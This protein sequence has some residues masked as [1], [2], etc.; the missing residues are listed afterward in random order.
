MSPDIILTTPFKQ[1][2]Y[3]VQIYKYYLEKLNNDRNDEYIPFHP[4]ENN[5]ILVIDSGKIQPKQ[6]PTGIFSYFGFAEEG[7]IDYKSKRFDVN[8]YNNT[9]I[10]GLK[11]AIIFLAEITK[12]IEQNI[13]LQ[14]NMKNFEQ[15]EKFIPPYEIDSF[16]HH[17]RIINDG[18]LMEERYVKFNGVNGLFE[19][20]RFE[21][22]DLYYSNFNFIPIFHRLYYSGSSILKTKPDYRKYGAIIMDENY[23]THKMNQTP[24]HHCLK[25]PHNITQIR[26]PLIQRE[27][28]Y[29]RMMVKIIIENYCF[30]LMNMNKFKCEINSDILNLFGIIENIYRLKNPMKYLVITK[31]LW[32]NFHI[33]TKN[34]QDVLCK[35]NYDDLK[36]NDAFCDGAFCNGAFC[37]GMYSG[38]KILENLENETKKMVKKCEK[39]TF[40][41]DPHQMIN[42]SIICFYQH[43]NVPVVESGTNYLRWVIYNN[44]YRKNIYYPLYDTFEG[45]FTHLISYHKNSLHGM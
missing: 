23:G 32:A 1:L 45:Q 29:K 39:Y 6:H 28:Y 38:R 7:E 8:D 10:D 41:N 2:E 12:T 24:T 9:N 35:I 43:F 19:K 30:M 34:Y 25:K 31:L 37:N 3:Y 33:M 4:L 22:N 42:H 5:D 36:N 44:P 14:S 40:N 11:E 26:N 18:R 13:Q 21:I 15:Y 20:I 16:R 27:Y 17:A